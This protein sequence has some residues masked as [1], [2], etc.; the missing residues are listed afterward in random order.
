MHDVSPAPPEPRSDRESTKVRDPTSL[1]ETTI[2]CSGAA[3]GRN[4]TRS[5][6]AATEDVLESYSAAPLTGQAMI[7]LRT[8]AVLRLVAIL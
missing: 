6:G 3:K 1:L 2:E 4:A 7:G 5:K 8:S